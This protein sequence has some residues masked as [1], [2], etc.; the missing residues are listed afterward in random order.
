MD[1]MSAKVNKGSVCSSSIGRNDRQV[2]FV[3][4]YVSANA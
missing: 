3:S 1:A 4:D 2:R